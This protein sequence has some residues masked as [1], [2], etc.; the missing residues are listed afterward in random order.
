MVKDAR[1]DDGCDFAV[2]QNERASILVGAYEYIE[3]LQRQVQELYSELDTEFACSDDEVSSC[4]DEY[5]SD[6]EEER[7][8]SSN[9][10]LEAS[11]AECR[12]CSHPMV[13]STNLL[14]FFY[15]G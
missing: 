6:D 13:G 1:S 9:P 8:V 3:K 5:F 11:R 7:P 10:A 12:G 2:V 14:A 15:F 4:E